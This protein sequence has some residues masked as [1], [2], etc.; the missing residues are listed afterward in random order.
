MQEK[1]E[2][3][4]SQH[5]LKYHVKKVIIGQSKFLLVTS[6]PDEGLMYG[7]VPTRVKPVVKL[8]VQNKD[9]I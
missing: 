5:T 4:I 8:H 1:L 9:L 7:W 3:V 6:M 2:N